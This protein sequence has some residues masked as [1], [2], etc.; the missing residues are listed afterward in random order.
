MYK[1]RTFLLGNRSGRPMGLIPS[2][3]RVLIH[4]EVQESM[5]L[6]LVSQARSV[7]A[8]KVLTTEKLQVETIFIG[9]KP[10]LRWLQN[11][12]AKKI[13]RKSHWSEY[14][15]NSQARFSHTTKQDICGPCSVGQQ[16]EIYSKT[17]RDSTNTTLDYDQD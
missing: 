12:V 14:G 4:K 13:I 15:N 17:Q 3:L 10:M 6:C 8:S 9:S 2:I 5:S 7:A 16:K 11:Y 1:K